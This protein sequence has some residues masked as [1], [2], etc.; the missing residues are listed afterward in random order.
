M[1]QLDLL[2]LKQISWC[3]TKTITLIASTE[4]AMVLSDLNSYLVKLELL[5]FDQILSFERLCLA[6]VRDYHPIASTEC[7]DVLSEF[8]LVLC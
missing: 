3:Y 7:A 8:E 4:N 1:I 6:R 2:E 5:H